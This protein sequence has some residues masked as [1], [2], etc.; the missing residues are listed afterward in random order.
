MVETLLKQLVWKI[1]RD[2]F[3]FIL[4]QSTNF[5]K[6]CGK[7]AFC[8]WCWSYNNYGFTCITNS[9]K[10]NIWVWKLNKMKKFSLLLNSLETIKSMALLLNKL[11][12]RVFS[13]SQLIICL[14]NQLFSNISEII[15]LN[16]N[17]V[18]LYRQMLVV[19]RE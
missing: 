12:F 17:N 3:L 18:L 14:L 19:Q 6:A 7:H 1:K 11:F 8:C 9:G 16:G 4:E 10:Q 15:S 2:V 5:C 13:I